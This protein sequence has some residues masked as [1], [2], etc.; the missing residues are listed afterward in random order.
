MQWNLNGYWNNLHDL[1]LL[2]HDHQPFVI[3]LQEIHRINESAMNNTLRQRY[4]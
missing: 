1:E 2:A 4:K 3:A